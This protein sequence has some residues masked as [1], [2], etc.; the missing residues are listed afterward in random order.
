[1][2]YS[3]LVIMLNCRL[4]FMSFSLS[5][6]LIFLIASSLAKLTGYLDVYANNLLDGDSKMSYPVSPIKNDY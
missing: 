6:P 2:F 1:M 4:P 5:R 3:L